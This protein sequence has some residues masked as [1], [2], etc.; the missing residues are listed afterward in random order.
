[1]I[2]LGKTVVFG[3]KVANVYRHNP[4]QL[5]MTDKKNLQSK[6]L[7]AKDEAICFFYHPFISL[8]IIVTIISGY[9]LC[10][11]ILAK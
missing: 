8:T 5:A 6:L 1:M 2:A 11:Y 4:I 3:I 9:A 7:K 10:L